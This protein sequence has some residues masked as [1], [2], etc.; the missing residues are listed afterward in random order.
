[1]K[2]LITSPTYAPLI[3]GVP[4][5][6][7]LHASGFS[8][9]G[10]DVAVCTQ[11]LGQD[12]SDLP[13]RI[14]RAPSARALLG[15]YRWSDVVLQ[16]TLSLRLGWPL[17]LV[18]R[19]VVVAHHMWMMESERGSALARAKLL[20]ARR[21]YNVS[22]SNA[23]AASL[24]TPS[25]VIPNAYADDVFTESPVSV[26]RVGLVF[27]GRLIDAKG[28]QVL[29][30]ALA[31]LRKRR[32]AIPLT[33]IGDGPQKPELHAQ[34][35]RLALAEHVR[36]VGPLRDHD[37]AAELNAHR[38]LIVPSVWE[39]PFGIV[40]LEGVACGLV[41][42]VSRSGG[43]PDAIGPTG[44]IVPK[45]DPAALAEAIHSL[46]DSADRLR[47]FRRHAKAH[48]ERHTRRVI[49]QKYLDAL[50]A[51]SRRAKASPQ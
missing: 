30:G 43:L 35:Q 4:T 23:M 5:V 9:L 20:L 13:F 38:L 51:A 44:I 16:N 24:G 1:M 26:P 48:L 49:A 31:I 14:Y 37:L 41:P 6:T 50:A 42:I 32:E 21:A 8:E 12:P 27:V 3:G 45:G 17:A 47:E 34:V 11:T 29:L 19:P 2:I 7:A 10:H 18:R 25:E 39:E 46:Y 40:A 33:V 28:L 36:I 15:L 22:V